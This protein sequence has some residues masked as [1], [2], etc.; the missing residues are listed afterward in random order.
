VS[1]NLKLQEEKY[2]G[3]PA[4]DDNLNLD[5]DEEPDPSH[6]LGVKLLKLGKIHYRHI[7]LLPLWV[8]D[9]LQE[10]CSN[11]TPPQIRRCLKTWMISYD[12]SDQTIY[13]NKALGWKNALPEKQPKVIS[14][15]A[16]E[17]IAYCR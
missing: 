4:P 8:K 12:K 9:K 3:I 7:D 2:E 14:Y 10:I 11:R 5:T 1:K 6:R 13:K 16:E 17:T 15:G